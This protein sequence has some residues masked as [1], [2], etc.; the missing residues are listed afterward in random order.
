LFVV[1]FKLTIFFAVVANQASAVYAAA[2]DIAWRILRDTEADLRPVF[3]AL[4]TSLHVDIVVVT[5]FTRE[6]HGESC[7][8]SKCFLVW[9]WY[10]LTLVIEQP[11]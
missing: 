5:K 11:T 2:P 1:A 4:A 3:H 8:S 7:K 9:Y 6:G 10:V